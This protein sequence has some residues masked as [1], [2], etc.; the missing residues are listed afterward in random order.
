MSV[1][2]PYQIKKLW[3]KKKPHLDSVIELL[4]V[5]WDITG[6]HSGRGAGGQQAAQHSNRLE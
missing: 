5:G 1:K 3:R 6:I 4:K 2:L